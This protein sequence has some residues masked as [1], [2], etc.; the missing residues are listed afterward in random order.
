MSAVINS[1]ARIRALDA[2]SRK[3]AVA[4]AV[5]AGQKDAGR[6]ATLRNRA[7]LIV[8]R[9]GGSPL[10]PSPPATEAK[11]R[12]DIARLDRRIDGLKRVVGLQL[13]VGLATLA[14][15]LAMAFGP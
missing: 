6:P 4:G 2:A 7:P 5:N 1:A 8:A 9:K 11:L 3:A 10:R 13:A 15:V 12:A 14:A